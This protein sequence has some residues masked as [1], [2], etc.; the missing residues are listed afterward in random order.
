LQDVGRIA[1]NRGRANGPAKLFDRRETF[2][3]FLR[4]SPDH[5]GLNP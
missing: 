3:R 5:R 4:Q 2:F 1:T